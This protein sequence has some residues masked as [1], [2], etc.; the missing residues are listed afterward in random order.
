[1]TEKTYE[2]RLR[3]MANRQG[4]IILKSRTRDTR[5][6]TYGGW[7]VCD[8]NGNIIG[9]GHPHGY[10]MSVDEIE[11]YLTTGERP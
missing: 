1:M 5:A 3:R 7:M 8:G 4:L 2:D 11:R 6:L 9:G 10:S